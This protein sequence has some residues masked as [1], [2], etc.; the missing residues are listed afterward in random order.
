MI[1][2]E[3]GKSIIYDYSEINYLQ[4]WN[5]SFHRVYYPNRTPKK[6]YVHK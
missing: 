3:H 5:L 1:S 4:T 6:L 2:R